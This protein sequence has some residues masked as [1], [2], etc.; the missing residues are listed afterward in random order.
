MFSAYL[1]YYYKF[2]LNVC[3]AQVPLEQSQKFFRIAAAMGGTIGLLIFIFALVVFLPEY[4]N[5]TFIVGGMLFFFQ[6]AMI[7]AS[8]MC[9]KKMLKMC[10][11]YFQETIKTECCANFTLICMYIYCNMYLNIYVRSIA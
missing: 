5:I 3:A 9:T 7:F 4:S 8:L 10:K 1:V 6:Q 11:G 2:N